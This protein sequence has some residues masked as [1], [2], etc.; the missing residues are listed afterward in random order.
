VLVAV[1][2]EDHVAEAVLHAG[3]F[4]HAVADRAHRRAAGRAV[5]HAQVARHCFRM[6]CN[7]IAKPLVTR[8]NSTGEA[9]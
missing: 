4:D 5:V 8:E 6:G 3:E 2:D 9:R 1:L 7:R